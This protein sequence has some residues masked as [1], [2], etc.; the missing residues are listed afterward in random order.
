MKGL[1]LRKIFV[2]GSL[3]K[4]ILDAFDS[5]IED[6]KIISLL[7]TNLNEY[8]LIALC[9]EESFASLDTLQNILQALSSIAEKYKSLFLLTFT[10][11][12]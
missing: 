9:R 10:L 11:I 4:E 5:N 6:G 3:K 2:T 1:V 8:F 12:Q 7:N